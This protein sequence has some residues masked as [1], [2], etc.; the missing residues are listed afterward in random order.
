MSGFLISEKTRWLA[1]GQPFALESGEF[2]PGVEIAYRTW[3]ELSPEADNAVIVCHALTGS[4]DVDAWWKDF[5][6]PGKTLD[7]GRDFIVCS[8]ALGA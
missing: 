6:G 4:A 7:P 1:L 5:F 3:G 8:N 2:L